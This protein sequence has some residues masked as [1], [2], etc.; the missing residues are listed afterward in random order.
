MLLCADDDPSARDLPAVP[1]RQRCTVALR[2]VAGPL[3]GRVLPLRDRLE[4]GAGGALPL[5][6]PQDEAASLR[7]FWQD[8]R[9]LLETGARTSPR[10]PLHLNGVPVRQPTGLAPGDQVGVAMHRFV[11]DAPGMQPE[12]EIVLPEPPPRAPLPEDVAGPR[13][14]VWWLIATAAVIALG[15]ALALLVRF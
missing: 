12:P 6:L 3:S 2:A 14:E 1:E 8:S 15:I 9:L 13:G 5:E 7:V 11:V 10:Y 4:L